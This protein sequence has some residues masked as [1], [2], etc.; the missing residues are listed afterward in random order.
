VKRA[1]LA[2]K[3]TLL[4]GHPYWQ[5][6]VPRPG[7][8]RVRKTFKDRAEAEAYF[9]FMQDRLA[10]FGTSVAGISDQPRVE[11]TRALRL[12]ELYWISVLQLHNTMWRAEDSKEAGGATRKAPARSSASV[13]VRETAQTCFDALLRCSSVYLAYED[14]IT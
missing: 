11:V 7:G 8:G 1:R 14:V 10:D 12:I 9:K 4:R 3:K 13:R 6:T 2:L 5:V